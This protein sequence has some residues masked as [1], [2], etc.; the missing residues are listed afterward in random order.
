M[1]IRLEN[2]RMGVRTKDGSCNLFDGLDLCI[3]PGAHVG[4]LGLPKSG[5]TTLL[6]LMS[7]TEWNYAGRITHGMTCSWPIPFESFFLSSSSIAWGLRWVARLYGVKDPNFAGR[8]AGMAQAGPFINMTQ[9]ECPGP[10]RQQLA[11]ALPLALDFDLYLF[12]NICVPGSKEYKEIGKKLLADRTAG[13]AIVIA[14]GNEGEVAAYC[15]SAYVLE[16]GQG[17]YFPDVQE[18]VKYF[19]ELKKAEE[20]KQKLAAEKGQREEEASALDFEAG[21]LDV[22]GAAIA[23][24]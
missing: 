12:D 7:G 4:I 14:T 16:N 10:V 1:T 20:A 24:I 3:E 8:V 11:F 19:K 9:S 22:L 18:G 17:R 6:R 13:R 2:L 21:G 23:D 15:Q 5:K